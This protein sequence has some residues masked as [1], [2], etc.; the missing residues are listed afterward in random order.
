MKKI[1]FFP[2]LFA[3]LLIL[4]GC[5]DEGMV[6]NSMQPTNG[7]KI[8]ANS[9]LRIHFIYA[10]QADATL[11]QLKENDELITML[12]DT[13]DWKRKDVVSY[14]QNEKISDIDL[15]AITHPHADHIGQLDMILDSFHVDEV[16]MNGDT[17]NAQAFAN[18]LEAIEVHDVGY[19][20]PRAG[21]S[22]EIGGLT[23]DVI[24]PTDNFSKTNKNSAI[25]NNSIVMR[26][27]YGDVSFLFTGDAELEAEKEMLA[28]SLELNADIL[29]VGHHGSK[30]SSSEEF[31]EAVNAEIAVY[32]AGI[33]NSYGLPDQEVIDRLNDHHSLVYGTDQYG[34]I[35]LETNGKKVH[36][37]TEEEGIVPPP[38][39]GEGCVDVNTAPAEELQK[40]IHIGEKSAEELIKLRPYKSLN[41][42]NI[43]NGIGAKRLKDIKKQKLACIG[44]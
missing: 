2:F 13:G 24:H 29:H 17:N 42:L 15:V 5:A 3:I 10:G 37:S 23:I 32:S 35:T 12:I 18:A 44:G 41:E 7:K 1:K 34:T 28:S 36:I 43:I 30:T 33:D 4:A 40:I 22:F 11:L 9:F 25:N 39:E 21:E 26:I 38:V 14:L 19:Y 31:L 20:E 16:W 8:E 27:Q 6:E